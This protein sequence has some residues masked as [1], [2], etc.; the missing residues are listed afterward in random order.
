MDPAL[1]ILFAMLQ[2]GHLELEKYEKMY[3]STIKIK[4]EVL[5]LSRNTAC[6]V[7]T[8]AIQRN[9]ESEIETYVQMSGITLHE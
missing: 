2:P 9:I 1:T 7:L 4:T 6:S 8:A 5:C 3:N